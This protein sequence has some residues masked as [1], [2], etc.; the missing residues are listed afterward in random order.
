MVLEN[1]ILPDGVILIDGERIV[2]IGTQNEISLPQDC[3]CI[4]AGGAYVG[5]GFVDIHT[6]SDGSVFFHEDPVRCSQ[7]H[8]KNGTT[9]LLPALYTSMNTQQYI[10]A[11]QVIVCILTRSLVIYVQLN[12][13]R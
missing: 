9:S 2:A 11:V 7:H 13:R 4:D 8:L 5:P 10:D 3:T 6:H 1:S 12:G